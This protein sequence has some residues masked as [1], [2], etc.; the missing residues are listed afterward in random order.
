MKKIFVNLKRFEV[1][2]ALGGICP[3]DNP[4]EWTKWV[5][6]ETVRLGL[7]ALDKVQITYFWQEALL[8][9]AIE[10][11]QDVKPEQKKNLFL[12]CQSVFREDIKPGGNFGA[13]SS[14]RPATAMKVLGCQWAMIGHSEERRDKLQMFTAYDPKVATDA[15]ASEKAYKALDCLLSQ[16]VKAAKEAGLDV[17]FCVGES[18]EQKGEGDFDAYAPRV[19]AVLEQQIRNGLAGLSADQVKGIV[20][21]YEP[22]WAIGPGKT[23]PDSDYISFVSEFIKEITKDAFSQELDVIYG[24][25]LKEENAASI[26]AIETIDGGLVALTKFVAPI[27]FDP[28]SFLKIVQAYVQA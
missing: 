3:M 14:N 18:F 26:A 13:F 6:D 19:R 10:A 11:L 17:V 28:E 9:T 15:Q 7:G 22:I 12:G 20:I 4:L 16:E 27:G 8:P 21:G 1:S 24:G 25:G 5:M 2:R 23:P